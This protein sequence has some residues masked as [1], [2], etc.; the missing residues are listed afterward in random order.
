MKLLVIAMPYIEK[1]KIWKISFYIQCHSECEIKATA[2]ERRQWCLS[3]GRFCIH[4][5]PIFL[6]LIS[7]YHQNTQS[8]CFRTGNV[9]RTHR[10]YFVP[11]SASVEKQF[12][13]DI[14]THI[15]CFGVCL[16][17][18]NHISVKRKTFFSPF[19]PI[20]FSLVCRLTHERLWNDF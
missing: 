10:A 1:C 7:L 13:F 8:T 20:A 9:K 14:F 19:C 17:D 18:E 5:F 12:K 2:A 6:L 16:I 15:V 3:T 4:G 11:S